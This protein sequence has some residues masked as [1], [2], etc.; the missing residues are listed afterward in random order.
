MRFE[1]AGTITS[2]NRGAE[3]CYAYTADEAIGQNVAILVDPELR[4]ELAG[5]L[6]RV[7][8]GEAVQHVGLLSRRKDGGHAEVSVMLSPI[9]HRVKI[10]GAAAIARDITQLTET[11][12]ALEEEQH[13]VTG[14]L[15]RREEF[16]AMLSHEL[17][18]PLAAVLGATTVLE[19]DE[20]PDRV[21]RC[22]TVIQRQATHMARLLDDMLDVSRITTAK[23]AIQ[24]ES[25]DLR[26]A[27]ETAIESTSPLFDERRIRLETDVPMRSLPVTGD[28]RRL[29]QV[30]GNLLANAAI[31]SPCDTTVSLVVR[32]QGDTIVIRVRDQG[33][34][35]DPALQPKIFDL[36]VQSEQKLD[37]SRGGLGVGLSLAKTIVELHRGTIQVRSD[38]VGTGSEFEVTLP[39]V[40]K[41]VIK[42]P[43][44]DA[45][46]GAPCRIVLV[47]D[48]DDSRDMLKDLLEARQHVVFDAA[49]GGRAV[50]LIAEVK[51]DVA[52]ID[53]GLPVMDGFEVAQ[54]IRLRPELRHIRLVALSGYG[55]KSDVQAALQAGFD[56]HVTKP[57]ELQQLEQILARVRVVS[58]EPESA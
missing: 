25:L 14:L 3:R 34:G 7:A 20:S 52:F 12:R 54:Q 23:F 31:Y 21:R 39:L 24:S 15:H 26:D 6:E 40:R 16:L 36:F 17:R 42:P 28:T 27:I 30:I 19:E 22:R 43:R 9:F 18:N 53:I 50:Q 58:P 4:G 29:T 1:L 44:V 47:D 49:D 8:Q 35:I 48:Q 33:E 38:G 51:P 13:K 37:R 5:Y 56:D 2:W 55:N 41:L 11:Q 10:A 46:R 32:T 45:A 57:A